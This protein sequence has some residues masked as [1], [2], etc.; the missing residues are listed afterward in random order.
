MSIEDLFKPKEKKEEDTDVTEPL[1]E[2]PTT[3][4]ESVVEPTVEKEKEET[5][6]ESETQETVE[7]TQ[8]EVS[9]TV[10]QKEQSLTEEAGS[11]LDL[12]SKPTTPGVTV[13]E[14]VVEPV[15]EPTPSAEEKKVEPVLFSS[16][17]KAA[18]DLAPSP[19]PRMPEKF[20][21]SSETPS[22]SHTFMIY[23][24][25][26]SSKTTTALSFPGT[27]L[28]L[29]FDHKTVEIWTEMFNEDPRI[30]VKDAIRYYEHTSPDA[31]LMSSEISFQYINILLDEAKALPEENRP[32]W[33]L[34]DGLEIYTRI[35]EMLMR[36]RNGLRVTSGV[37]WN[38][39]KD[40]RLYLKQIH[41]KAMSI[42]RKGVI[43]T[44]YIKEG[45]TI[46]NGQIVKTTKKPKWV[47]I[48]KEQTD[49]Q[50]LVESSQVPEGRRFVATV[51]NSKYRPMRTGTQVDITIPEGQIPDIYE[52][53][54]KGR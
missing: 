1:E 21:T 20:D 12:F 5:P 29:S 43:Y 26:G 31:W 10:E 15:V 41:I 22:T 52:I 49:V 11:V 8:E 42:A 51:E 47:D 35:A 39:W 53:I 38:I 30:T 17:V 50:I 36:Y 46:E 7:E 13:I 40:R 32:D 2:E 37:E 27:I 34:I 28:A 19:L 18:T 48:I 24:N 3:Q 14:P 4:V 16:T 25:K 45:S 33:I 44:T 6:A 54:V 23:G 9:P